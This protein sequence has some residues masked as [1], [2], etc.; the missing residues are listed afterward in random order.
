MG[1]YTI[2]TQL[3][4]WDAYDFL[5]EVYLPEAPEKRMPTAS[6]SRYIVGK[7][8]SEQDLKEYLDGK[9]SIILKILRE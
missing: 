5:R 7:E 8:V 1:S 2:D 4:K 6:S 9:P 3:A